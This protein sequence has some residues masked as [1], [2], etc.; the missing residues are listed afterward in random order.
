MA[1]LITVQG[2]NKGRK[3]IVWETHPKHV[4]KDNPTGEIFIAGEE[5]A[6]VGKTVK[7]QQL[8]ASGALVEAKGKTTEPAPQ[9]I[10]PPVEAKTRKG[11]TTEA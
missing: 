8:L 10:T 7:V 3:V 1:D 4:T 6:T 2:T 5:T 9:A 11:S